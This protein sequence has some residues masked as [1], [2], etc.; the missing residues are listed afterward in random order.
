MDRFGNAVTNMAPS[1]LLPLAPLSG[2]EFEAGG[3]RLGGL[4]ATYGAAEP[5]A[6]VALTGSA[7]LIEVA[8]NRGSAAELLH[9]R[10]GSPV[11]ARRAA[12][13]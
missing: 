1:D 2:W 4:A 10:P 13:P 8:V 7:G 6:P 5:G 12:R 9:L 11:L 3:A